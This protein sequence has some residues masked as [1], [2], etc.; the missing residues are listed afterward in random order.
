ML[1]SSVIYASG[2]AADGGS[3]AIKAIPPVE[4]Y[5]MKWEQRQTQKEQ[6]FQL[7]LNPKLRNMI[8]VK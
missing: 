4:V 8:A 6:S 5:G 1:S 2:M 3:V 7:V